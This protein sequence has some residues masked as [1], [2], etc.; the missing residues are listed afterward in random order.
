MSIAMEQDWSKPF[1]LDTI[2][3]IQGF[4]VYCATEDDANLFWDILLCNGYA[5]GEIFEQSLWWENR[6]PCYRFEDGAVVKCGSMDAYESIEE[7]RRLPK[8]T[9]YAN[10]FAP[11]ELKI[12]DEV[13]MS[14]I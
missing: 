6:F 12:P 4:C 7:W 9:F 8:F 2:E 5:I 11:S 14:I 1:T 13:A 10:M 3:S